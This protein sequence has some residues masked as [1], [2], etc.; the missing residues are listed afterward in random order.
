MPQRGTAHASEASIGVMRRQHDLP[1][2][3]DP[4]V[5]TM[6][7]HRPAQQPTRSLTAFDQLM[8]EHDRWLPSPF[9]S[10]SE[11]ERAAERRRGSSLAI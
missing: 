7:L 5:V 2:P 3:F 1:N 9:E 6:M 11:C 10:D 8:H 4:T